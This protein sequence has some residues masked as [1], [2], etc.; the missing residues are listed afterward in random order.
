MSHKVPHNIYCFAWAL[1]GVIRDNL[2]PCIT[3]PPL[4]YGE[5][6]TGAISAGLSPL[7]NASSRAG[8]SLD[9]TV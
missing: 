6:N 9:I 4:S 2:P 7:V 3:P 5:L 1:M 8:S